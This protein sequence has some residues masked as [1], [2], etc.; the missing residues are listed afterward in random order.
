M[1]GAPRYD[2]DEVRT[3]LLD[4]TD[5]LAGWLAELASPDW[6][7]PSVLPGW[8]VTVLTGHV[9]E[10]LRGIGAVLDR[11]GEVWLPMAEHVRPEYAVPSDADRVEE[12]ATW[13]HAA[14]A[15]VLAEYRA[16][17]AAA[18]ARL[19][20][21]LPAAVTVRSGPASTTDFL[22]TRIWELVVHADDL[23]RSVPDR[24]APS[25]D[26]AA[27]R[28]A[29]R[30]FAHLLAARAPGRSVELRIPPH[31]AVQ[32]VAGPRH[33]RGTPPNVVETDPLS[34]VRLATGRSAWAAAVAAGQVRASGERSD[35]SA[36]LPLLA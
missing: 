36:Y 7:G 9:C 15:D 10:V 5:Q 11:P 29:A 18:R 28:L 14:P 2:L 27:V 33:T 22:L 1:P 26:R 16:A 12:A 3:A 35:L 31:V 17:S 6:A 13:G 30:S 8:T 25:H 19:T 34:W 21:P 23:A 32:C 24:P 4:Q 20:G